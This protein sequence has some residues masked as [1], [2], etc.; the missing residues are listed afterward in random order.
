MAKPKFCDITAFADCG[1]DGCLSFGIV[2]NGD[3]FR[4]GHDRRVRV[5]VSALLGVGGDVR[6]TARRPG[7]VGS[8]LGGLEVLWQGS[9]GEVSS[10][11]VGLR[12]V[13]VREVG[14]F[15]EGLRT[16]GTSE[17]SL[18]EVSLLKV[19]VREV[20]ANERSLRE[21]GV[22]E[23]GVAEI[24]IREVGLLEVNQRHGRCEGRRQ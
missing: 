8:V 5:V 12:E 14:S 17:V 20:G 10:R 24:G 13:N 15:E 22:R 7:L 11:E 1:D 23:V 6:V 18:R 21:V 4:E 16:V 2:N 19:S 9:V 3:D